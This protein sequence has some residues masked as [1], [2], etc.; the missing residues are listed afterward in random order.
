M[1]IGKKLPVFSPKVTNALDI[2][3]V[4]QINPL[5]HGDIALLY[6]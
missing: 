4:L 5:P 1:I 6:T 2:Y 3:I